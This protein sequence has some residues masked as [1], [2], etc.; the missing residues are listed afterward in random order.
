MIKI[1]KILINP[2]DISSIHEE[3]KPVTDV[4]LRGIQIIQII[5]KNG[6]I[7]NFNSQEIGM[8][9][10][11]FIEQFIKESEKRE[12]DRIFKTIIG[13]NSLNNG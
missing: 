4:K 12:T 13:L 10:S 8:G 11:E 3:I 9:Y 2:D 7:K 6:V 1:G 5:Y